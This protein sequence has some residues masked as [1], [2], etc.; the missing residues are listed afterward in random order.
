M[1]VCHSIKLLFHRYPFIT[2]KVS[3][4]LLKAESYGLDYLQFLEVESWCK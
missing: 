3:F 1:E 4:L 2:F